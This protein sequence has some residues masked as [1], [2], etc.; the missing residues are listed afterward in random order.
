MPAILERKLREHGDHV[1]V[2]NLGIRGYGTDQSVIRAVEYAEKYHPVD[3]IYMY[4]DNDNYENNTL[5][6]IDWRI[7][8]FGKGVYIKSDGMDDFSAFQYPVPDQGSDYHG[9]IVFDQEC[10]PV[11]YEETVP[12]NNVQTAIKSK[13]EKSERSLA[14]RIRLF[15]QDHSYAVRALYFIKGSIRDRAK[16]VDLTTIDPYDLFFKQDMKLKDI[17]YHTITKIEESYKDDGTLRRRCQDYFNSQLEFLIKMM[18]SG[19]GNPHLYVAQFP[20]S[21]TISL[22]R[23]HSGSPN[24]QLF[25]TLEQKEIISSHINLSQIAIDKDIDIQSY[26]CKGD[27]HFCNKGNLWIASEIYQRLMRAQ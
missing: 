20:G 11:L 26:T 18:K 9:M 23:K 13:K 5:R 7:K 8:W 14:A 16:K 21:N 17:K 2:L 22:L 27:R 25:D 12:V 15:L 1:N 24:S 3:I 6:Q 19:S 4:T 10:K